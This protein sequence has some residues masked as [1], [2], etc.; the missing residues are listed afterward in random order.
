[1]VSNSSR[2]TGNGNGHGPL[3]GSPRRGHISHLPVLLDERGKGAGAGK[4]VSA[5]HLPIAALVCLL[6]ATGAQLTRERCRDSAALIPHG[7]CP[8]LC[9]AC[10]SRFTM[11][12]C[13][14]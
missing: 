7:P 4:G 8:A 1:M 13:Q 10:G 9:L 2:A 6:A 12:A 11:A 14:A 3:P 5:Q